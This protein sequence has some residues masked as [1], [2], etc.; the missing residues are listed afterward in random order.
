MAHYDDDRPAPSPGARLCDAGSRL[1]RGDR[2]GCRVRKASRRG[3]QRRCCARWLSS[4]TGVEDLDLG[5]ASRGL[6]LTSP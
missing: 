2:S 6:L 1:L 3:R 5:V 4:R